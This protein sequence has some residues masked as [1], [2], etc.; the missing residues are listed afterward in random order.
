MH[1]SLSQ[2]RSLLALLSSVTAFKKLDNALIDQ[3]AKLA[4]YQQ[5]TAGAVILRQDEHSPEM[6]LIETGTIKISR[7]SGTRREYILALLSRGKTFNDVSALDGGPNPAT[8]I[9]QTDSRI[10]RFSC[11]KLVKLASLHPTL[12]LALAAN[13]STYA[14]YLVQELE[15]LS[16]CSVK[17]RLA[18][19]LLNQSNF[20]F[21]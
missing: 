18:R 20:T 8:V 15:G 2:E 9:A 16:M 21:W 10:W 4:S 5:Y 12:A 19:F 17:A 3:L 13:V 11:E 14:R 6:Y 7:L 1:H